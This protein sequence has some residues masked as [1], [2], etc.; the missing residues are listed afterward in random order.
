MIRLLSE[1]DERI[2]EPDR[3]IDLSC[4]RKRRDEREER[5]KSNNAAAIAHRENRSP[6]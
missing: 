4:E 2:S 1:Y 3:L 5:K 6:C